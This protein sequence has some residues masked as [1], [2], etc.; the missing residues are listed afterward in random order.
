MKEKVIQILQ[1]VRP[2][3]DFESKVNF[4]TEGYL[5]SFDIVALVTSLDQEF[6]ISIDGLDIIPDNFSSIEGIIELLKKNGIAE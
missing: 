2:E 6:N 5:D 4:V 1:S 3:F